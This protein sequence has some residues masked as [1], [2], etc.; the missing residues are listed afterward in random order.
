M[1]KCPCSVRSR[2]EPTKGPSLW[3]KMESCNFWRSIPRHALLRKKESP[4]Y[5]GS[6]C[7]WDRPKMD[8]GRCPCHSD[9]EPNPTKGYSV[10]C[11]VWWPLGICPCSVKKESWTLP[12]VHPCEVRWLFWDTSVRRRAATFDGASLDENLLCK[13]K[14]Q[15]YWWSSCV[16]ED[17]CWREISCYNEGE[18]HPTEG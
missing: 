12:M 11:P 4:I 15:I 17:R 2:T 6:S 10:W 8:A 14:S 16:T 13:K 5:L 9:G 1:A 7:M 18:P 3:S